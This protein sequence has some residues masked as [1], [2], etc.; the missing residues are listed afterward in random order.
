[1]EIK[2]RQSWDTPAINQ[3]QKNQLQ[4]RIIELMQRLELVETTETDKLRELPS[5]LSR[6]L[7][8]VQLDQKEFEIVSSIIAKIKRK[9]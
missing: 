9:L 8:R 2:Q 4:M 7:S 3:Q 1:I 5:R 6:L